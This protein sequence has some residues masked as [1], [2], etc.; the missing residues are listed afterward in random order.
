VSGLRPLTAGDAAALGSFYCERY[1]QPWTLAVQDAIRHELPAAL[2]NGDVEGIA[3]WDGDDLIGVI[4]WTVDPDDSTLWRSNVLAV[5]V[6][7][8]RHGHGLSLKTAL[9]EAAAARG[10]KTVISIVEWDNDPMIELNLRK[11][12]ADVAPDPDGPYRRNVI[13]TI[14]VERWQATRDG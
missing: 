14:S 7:R 2:A 8:Q 5:M 1:R 3:L 10:A 11:F 9:I 12:N 4:A 6:G 13:C